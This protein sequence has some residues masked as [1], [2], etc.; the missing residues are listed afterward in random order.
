MDSWTD[1]ISCSIDVMKLLKRLETAGWAFLRRKGEYA[2]VTCDCI[3][4]H[5]GRVIL[6][7]SVPSVLESVVRHLEQTTCLGSE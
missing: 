5:F 6:W 2:L 4:K 1:S 7:P 3:E